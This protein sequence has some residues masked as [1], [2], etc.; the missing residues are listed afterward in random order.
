MRSPA[1]SREGEAVRR[2]GILGALLLLAL[3]GAGPARGSEASGP[4]GGASPGQPDSSAPTNP[5]RFGITSFYNPRIMYQK[6][7][8][9]IDYLCEATG[10]RW[11]MVLSPTYLNTVDLLCRGRVDVAYLGPSIYLRARARC[12]AKPVVRLKAPADSAHRSLILVRQDSDIQSLAELKGKRFAFGAPL[13]ASSHLVPRSML[14]E[15]GLRPGEDL[16]CLYFDQHERAARAVLLGDADACGIRDLPAERF[17]GRG[18]RVLARSVTSLQFPLA[19]GPGAPPETARMLRQA[20]ITLPETLPA[21]R[22]RMETW[23]REISFGFSPGSD[24]DFDPIRALS[25]EV[26]GAGYLDLGVDELRCS[27]G[28]R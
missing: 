18:L 3:T 15:A 21:I 26:F 7:Q 8:P 9:L 13:S 6:Y 19:V 12:G 27:P 1:P 22:Q 24:A 23:D 17:I 20:L 28:G 16:T 25:E 4:G 2:R 10:R 11:E 5:L 14:L